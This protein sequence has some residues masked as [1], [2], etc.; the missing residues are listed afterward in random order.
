LAVCPRNSEEHLLSLNSV[1]SKCINSPCF[2]HQTPDKILSRDMKRG[3]MEHNPK[4]ELT[5]KL[6]TIQITIITILI[7]YKYWA[8]RSKLCLERLH[9]PILI[10]GRIRVTIGEKAQ[11]LLSTCIFGF[12]PLFTYTSEWHLVN[13]LVLIIYLV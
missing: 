9:L 3:Q 4:R 12:H 13:S 6:I 10:D 1:I 5:D 8:V 11:S 7:A 2:L